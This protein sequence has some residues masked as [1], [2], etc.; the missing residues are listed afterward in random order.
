LSNYN[1]IILQFQEKNGFEERAKSRE[2]RAKSK[3]P[4]GKGK[5]QRVKRNKKRVKIY[6]LNI[7]LT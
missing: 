3:E 5:E 4:R 2:E 1:K 6:T 7:H